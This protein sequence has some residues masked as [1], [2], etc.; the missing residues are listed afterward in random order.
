MQNNTQPPV[1][2]IGTVT[3]GVALIV[4]GLVLCASLCFPQFD[5]IDLCRF[6]PL[7]L[8]LLGAEILWRTARAKDVS[9]RYDWL[10]MLLCAFLIACS[11]GATAVAAWMQYQAR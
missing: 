6:A 11:C 9:F 7:F 10:S 8:V 3:M 2:R 5:L 1:R 4:T